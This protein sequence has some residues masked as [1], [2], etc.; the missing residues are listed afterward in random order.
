MADEAAA[1]GKAADALYVQLIGD[2]R[3]Y[4][5]MLGSAVKQTEQASAAIASETKKIT[6]AVKNDV[7]ED[8]AILAH[9]TE[10]RLAK[11]GQRA[12]GSGLIIV[13]LVRRMVGAFQA[14][15][16][17]AIHAFKEAETAEMRMR[18]ALETHGGDVEKTMMQY[19]EFADEMQRTSTMAGTTAKALLNTAEGFGLTGEKAMR[20]VRDAQ[21]LSARKGGDPGQWMRAIS[22]LEQG[23][24]SREFMRL[25]PEIKKAKTEAEKLRLINKYIAESQ[26]YINKELDTASGNWR[27]L[28]NE[29]SDLFEIMG[30]EIV[31]ALKPFVDFG[32]EAARWFKALSPEIQRV[33]ANVIQIAAI[34]VVA[35]TAWG[36]WGSAIKD[37][38]ILFGMLLSK[39]GLIVAAIA[40]IGYAIYKIADSFGVWSDLKKI[41]KDAADSIESYFGDAWAGIV[42]AVKRGD[43]AMAFKIVGAAARTV[44]TDISNAFLDNWAKLAS[45]FS[46]LWGNLWAYLRDNW[47]LL[48]TWIVDNWKNVFV[49][50]WTLVKMYFAGFPPA[51]KA[52]LEIWT[53]LIATALGWWHGRLVT[54]FLSDL[55]SMVVSGIKTALTIAA[56]MV[57]ATAKIIAKVMAGA[58]VGELPG[59][60]VARQIGA[61][62]QE[63]HAKNMEIIKEGV[64]EATVVAEAAGTAYSKAYKAGLN[65]ESVVGLL[66]NVLKKGFAEFPNPFKEFVPTTQAFP[67]FLRF[68]GIPPL[69][70]FEADMSK[71]ANAAR[72][73]LG[74]LLDEA[75]DKEETEQALDWLADFMFEEAGDIGARTGQE[76]SSE[77]AKAL[78][79]DAALSD[80]AES[81][82]RA[83]E[84]Q[85]TGGTGGGGGGKGMGR[86]GAIGADTPEGAFEQFEQD[87]GD[88]VTLNEKMEGLLGDIRKNTGR[89]PIVLQGAGLA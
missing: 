52:A 7:A 20:A 71:F 49:D 45:W 33:T 73:E 12:V 47:G 70:K 44:W 89:D 78:R 42:S 69:P 22:F 16:G 13:G 80:S 43:L 18:G 61:A 26:K 76:L 77:F 1:A 83:W 32:I 10:S 21:A 41:A 46:S 72:D 38:V 11:V 35:T 53:Q 75:W 24:V 60:G 39:F 81:A 87:L 2:G 64:G 65:K 34:V 63:R 27:Q 86:F 5:N 4:K 67:A 58:L 15:E 28:K 88:M 84:F 59:M 31:K 74:N 85:M 79:F 8:S 19:R 82:F 30:K 9:M 37:I 50:A 40:G 17:A 48:F 57:V 68:L 55:P 36:I 3:S 66:G 14:Y 23:Q 56:G 62:L 25:T 54:F 29:V 51:L 6:E